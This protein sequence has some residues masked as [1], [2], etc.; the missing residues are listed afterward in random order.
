MQI[1]VGG[2]FNAES[3]HAS[4]SPK[5]R[6]QWPTSARLKPVPPTTDDYAVVNDVLTKLGVTV[7]RN[8][9]AHMEVIADLRFLLEHVSK[10][11]Y[12]LFFIACKNPDCA[13]GGHKAD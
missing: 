10:R 11:R 5:L 12:G 1:G 8:T 13:C 7:I 4:P 6:G 3:C 9:P 2:R